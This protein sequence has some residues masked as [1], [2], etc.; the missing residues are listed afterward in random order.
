[1]SF[2]EERLKRQLKKGEVIFRDGN[3]GQSMFILLEGQVVISKILGD[4]ETILA[5]LEPG[6]IFGEMAI[7]D[8]Q[9][10]SATAIAATNA[11]LLEI[12]REMFRNRMEEVPRWLQTFFAILVE[13]LRSATRNQSILLT[14]GA[15]R[16]VVNL[17]AML[18]RLEQP[19][20]E[21]RILLPWSQAVITI[22]FYLGFNEERV[23]EMMNKLVSIHLS[24]S[25]MREGIGRVFLLESPE[26]FYQFAGYCWNRHMIETGHAKTM[27]EQFSFKDRHEVE[28]LQVLGEITEEQGAIEDFP[29]ELLAKRLQE[30]FGSPLAL[31][32]LLI[33][34][35]GQSGLLEAFN[36][37]GSEPAYR[38]NNKE[39][40]QEELAKVQ[41]IAELQACEKKIME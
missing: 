7:I 6:S 16:Q 4:Q 14:R 36:P 38:I 32:K 25:T 24:E 41:L 10:R 26:K 30:K 37:T 28:L 5:K 35:Y 11:V 34:S 23:N 12:S 39:L 19:D 40:F 18:A 15:G 21:G 31:Y 9:P 1:M 8:N 20:P 27:P 33:D 2:M 17:L 22:A 3:S 13:R 29:A